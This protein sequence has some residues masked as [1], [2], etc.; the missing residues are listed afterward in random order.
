MSNSQANQQD[1]E[2]ILKLYDLR[3]EPVMRE[4][5][6]FVA[7]FSPASIDDVLAVVSNFGVKENAYLRQVYGYW[8]MV[9]ALIVHGTLNAALAYDT[10]QEMYFVYSI[11]QP[12]VEEFLQKANAPEFLKNVQ[13]VVESSPEGKERITVIRKRMAEFARMRAA[14]AKQGA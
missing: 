1:A 12:Y 13:K 10:L 3:R 6:N 8:E 2:L 11:M 14:T 7:T 9:A 5:R 4:A